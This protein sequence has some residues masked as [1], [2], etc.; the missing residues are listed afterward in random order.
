MGCLKVLAKDGEKE[1][2]YPVFKGEYIIVYMLLLTEFTYRS[3]YRRP[4]YLL[5]NMYPN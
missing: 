1:R 3:E 2:Y 5:S 4:Q